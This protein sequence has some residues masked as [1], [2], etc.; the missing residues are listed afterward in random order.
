MVK[1]KIKIEDLFEKLSFNDIPTINN[2]EISIKL[3]ETIK[4]KTPSGEFTPIRELVKK[5]CDSYLVKF[6]SGL[7]L[8]CSD[9]HILITDS[10]EKQ[11]KDI[12]QE[13]KVAYIDEKTSNIQYLHIVSKKLLKKNDILY[14]VCLDAPHL[15]VDS[16]GL[17]HHNS[18]II[19]YIWKHLYE[20]SIANRS[21][22]I[23][24]NLSLISQFTN[25]LIEYG[26]NPDLIGEV[27]A[28][29]KEWDKNIVISTWQSLVKHPEYCRTID[30]VIWDE[31]LDE[32]SLIT[33]YNKTRKKISDVKIGDEIL[34]FNTATNMY[35]KDVVKKI[36]RNLAISSSEKMYK[37]YFDNGIILEVT[38]NHKIL[39]TKG[40]IR[41]D[42]LT[43][44][45]EIINTIE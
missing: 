44:E 11:I 27:W 40:Y 36:M 23:V 29:K 6:N 39:T 22:I 33:M 12:S 8:I 18:L 31:C 2:P 15:F 42:A 32:N 26:V 14:D 28:S 30:C 24:P 17:I 25:D 5:L 4:V 16:D 20:N 1:I 45:H 34:S 19:T 9:K 37:L 10:G 41:A 3:S 7:E 13:D 38:G 21:F 43:F 35:E